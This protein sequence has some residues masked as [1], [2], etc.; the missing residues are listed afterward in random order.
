M[1]IGFA[2]QNASAR[3]S[4]GFCPAVVELEDLLANLQ[5][6]REARNPPRRPRYVSSYEKSEQ[7]PRSQRWSD[8]PPLERLILFLAKSSR[9]MVV[10]D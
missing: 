2:A 5:V 10:S 3:K 6:A 7:V 4:R 1:I 9:R 8:Q